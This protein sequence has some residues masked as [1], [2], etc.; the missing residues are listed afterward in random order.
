M[1]D[2]FIE[3]FSSLGVKL[4]VGGSDLG[5]KM[6][7][8]VM[9]VSGKM[10]EF[11]Q[12]P[13]QALKLV[14]DAT[15]ENLVAPDWSKNVDIADMIN[16]E[17]VSRQDIARAIKKRLLLK[18]P[19]IQL[20]CFSLLE[21]CVKNCDRMFCEV[22]SEGILDEMVD[23][24]ED[25]QTPAV[26]REKALKLIELWGESTEQLRY[27][28]VFEET[29]KSLK[30]RGIRFPGR[31]D[32]SLDPIFAPPLPV[33]YPQSNCDVLS[34][35]SGDILARQRNTNRNPGH[36]QE[37]LDVARNSAELL[38]TVLSSSPHNEALK[39]ELT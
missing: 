16:V 14:E 36:A 10:R 35:D 4:K 37:L 5:R 20:L 11:F 28:P 2:G 27:L 6:S 25:C 22:E 26:V 1:A 31:D 21:T 15:G 32:E 8:N 24:I 13:T 38:S 7:S 9:A 12:I 23:A 34:R 3:K 29:Y 17:Q 19:K 30:S 39:E 18:S 33:S